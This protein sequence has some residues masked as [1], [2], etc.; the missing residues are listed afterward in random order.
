MKNSKD[1]LRFFYPLDYERYCALY[2][3]P[4]G[5][6]FT[7]L[8]IKKSLFPRGFFGYPIHLHHSHDTGM[9]IGAVHAHCN[10]VLW[11]Y[12]GE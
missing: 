9:T 2:P 3:Q 1:Y 10:A 4:E 6:G 5:W 11:Q 7:A 12:E 8:L